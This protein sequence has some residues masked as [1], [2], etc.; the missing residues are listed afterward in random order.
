MIDRFRAAALASNFV[1]GLSL[2]GGAYAQSATRVAVPPMPGRLVAVDAGHRLHLWCTGNGAPTVVLVAGLAMASIEWQLV[3]PA[4]A[5]NSRVCSYDR[6]GIA[7][8]EKGSAPRG[9]QVSADELH[10]LL[11]RAEVLPPYVMVGMSWGGAIVRV[12]ANT[13]PD[14]VAGM[15][16]IDTY[17][18]GTVVVGEDILR[19]LD[20]RADEESD[21]GARLP[22]E[23][24]AAR[25]WATNL[26]RPQGTSSDVSDLDEP[27]RAIRATTAASPVPLGNKPLFVISAGRL[28]WD[29]QARA[30]GRPYLTALR[31]HVANEAYA[32]GLSTNSRFAVARG[33]FH[34]IHLYEPELVTNAILQ[35]LTSARTG[36]PLPP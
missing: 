33:S 8:S 7:W 32:A 15:V 31:A 35:V 18:E 1:V 27:E 9:F 26:A 14:E 34:S 6:A 5:R 17:P 36:R 13:H 30:S 19:R 25:T 20:P 3:Q 21:P 10:Q 12:F 11:R 2:A 23:W 4:V 29:A 24:R 16:L 28:S 22:A